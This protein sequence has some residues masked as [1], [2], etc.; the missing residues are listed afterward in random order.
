MS[1]PSVQTVFLEEVRQ[2]LPQHIAFADELAEILSISRDSAY[3]RIRGETVLSLDEVNA[4]CN[5]Y[6]IP[7][8]HLL[9]PSNDRVSFHN[10]FV[11]ENDFTFEK[12][13]QSLDDNLDMIRSVPH[14]EMIISAKDVPIF[15][16]FDT[17]F[18]SAFK[19]FFWMKSI[20]GYRGY[21]DQR[22]RPELVP[23]HL[24]SLGER[25]HAKFTSLSRSELWSDD[26]I[27]A[28][29][30]QIEFYH[31]CSFFVDPSQGQQLCDELLGC[32]RS[33]RDRAA[34]G[35]NRDVETPFNLFKNEILIADNTFLFKMGNQ[36]QIFINHNT[37][38]V[39]STTHE[40]FC[41]DTEKYLLHLLNK[42][43]KISGTG[44]R[45]RM[46]FFNTIEEKIKAL[47]KRIGV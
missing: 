4:I 18:I 1:A 24:L 12:W 8:D 30:R 23:R 14:H 38:N 26:T 6:K 39:L 33:I 21:V 25:I 29:L 5:N 47:K 43:T 22:F 31:D 7:L 28:S 13:L 45:E 20:L 36:R 27:H 2:R 3:R 37:L 35:L 32:M 16:Y 40:S 11:T 46:R 17:P 42:A 44:E 10:R 9:S 19:M 41:R 15:Y 34:T